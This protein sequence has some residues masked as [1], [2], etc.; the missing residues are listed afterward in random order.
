MVSYLN[1]RALV[2][3]K[4]LDVV[5]KDNTGENWEIVVI[6]EWLDWVS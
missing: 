1:E 5:L 6:G 4:P 2:F 3:E